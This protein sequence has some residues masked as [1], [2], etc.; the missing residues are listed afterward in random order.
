MPRVTDNHQ[1]PGKPQ[2]HEIKVE[3]MQKRADGTWK[4]NYSK[5]I[6]R[7]EEASEDTQE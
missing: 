1:Q 5:W 6:K 4:I 7:S 3:T 2:V